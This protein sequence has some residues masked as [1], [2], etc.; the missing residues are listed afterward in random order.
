[1]DSTF[2][3]PEKEGSRSSLTNTDIK[4][5]ENIGL[6]P[7]SDSL[8]RIHACPEHSPLIMVETEGIEPSS[9]PCKGASFPLAYV[10][11]I[12]V[13]QNGFEPLSLGYEPSMGASPPPRVIKL[14]SVRLDSH[15]RPLTLQAS[16]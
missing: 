14:W 13:A 3:T 10:P 4:M 2:L 1:M 5:V 11:V 9:A 8:Q 12:L 7:I 6:E 16:A 15:Q